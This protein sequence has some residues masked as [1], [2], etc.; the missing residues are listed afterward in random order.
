MNNPELVRK[1]RLNRKRYLD[2]RFIL[3]FFKEICNLT[4]NTLHHS[5]RISF[6]T[7]SVYL[8]DISDPFNLIPVI[9]NQNVQIPLIFPLIYFYDYL[10]AELANLEYLF[11]E[12]FPAFFFFA[13]SDK[14]HLIQTLPQVTLQL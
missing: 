10:A 13:N 14:Y 12:L 1:T 6:H 9:L 2:S 11:R 3:G 4:E 8:P 5:L 7:R